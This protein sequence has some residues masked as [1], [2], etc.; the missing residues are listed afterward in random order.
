VR[1]DLEALVARGA[2]IRDRVFGP[3]IRFHA[4]GLKHYESTEFPA[5][6]GAGFAAV[7]VTGAACRL[8][9]DHCRGV[10]LGSMHEAR[11]PAALVSLA[12]DL[13]SRG[14]TGLLVSGGADREGRVPLGPYVEAMAEI[15]EAHGMRVVVHT[16]LVDEQLARGLAAARVA[17]AMLDVVGDA[18]TMREVLH[19]DAGPGDIEES[20]AIL[21]D[22][23]V[24]TAPHVVVGLDHGRIA[25]E[26]EALEIVAR[27]SPSAL[28]IV[29]LSPIPG[30]PMAGASPPGLDDVAAIMA[31]ARVMLPAVPVMLG[32][33]RPPGPYRAGTD[34][35][36]LE[37]GLNGI[38]FPAEGTVSLARGMGLEPVFSRECCSLAPLEMPGACSI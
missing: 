11:D 36:A 34:R 12:S 6:P 14:C 37:A 31:L 22:H 25:G 32:C 13:A 35:L 21:E 38:A 3:R 26:H 7:S 27:G 24:R 28:V 1:D 30:T 16:G 19:L 17:C 9:C 33:A 18:R 29:V 2:R 5:S 20:L 23:G 15:V 8:G 4:P 10:L